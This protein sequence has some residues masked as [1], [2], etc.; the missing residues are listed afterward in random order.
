MDCCFAMPPELPVDP[1]LTERGRS[2][3]N[4]TMS[5]RAI[6]R[7][8][9]VSAVTIRHC[10]ASAEIRLPWTHR[11]SKPSRRIGAEIRVSACAVLWP[12]ATVVANSMPTAP[13]MVSRGRRSRVR[14]G[15]IDGSRVP[16]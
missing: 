5:P 1:S 7:S 8:E 3:R 13:T 11:P 10:S 16:D 6:V 15:R 2:V 4:A 14:I 12:A 9:G